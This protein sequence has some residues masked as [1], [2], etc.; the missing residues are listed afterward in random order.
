MTKKSQI[1]NFEKAVWATTAT[2]VTAATV[3][4]MCW[5]A[6]KG[7]EIIAKEIGGIEF[8]G[9]NILLSVKEGTVVYNC[10]HADEGLT[11]IFLKKTN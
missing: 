7:A 11:T 6:A 4:G 9:D 5:L 10:T 1:S 8:D 3:C 2:F